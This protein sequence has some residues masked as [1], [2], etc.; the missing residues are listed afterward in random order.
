MFAHFFDNLSN[1]FQNPKEGALIGLFLFGLT[2]AR[3]KLLCEEGL[4]ITDAA[5]KP[6][7]SFCRKIRTPTNYNE[8]WLGWKLQ[9]QTISFNKVFPSLGDVLITAR[10]SRVINERRG[11]KKEQVCHKVSKRKMSQL[12]CLNKKVQIYFLKASSGAVR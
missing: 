11:T 9:L 1:L 6:V 4:F 3:Y 7:V 2:K 5:V 10:Y 12:Q 8:Y